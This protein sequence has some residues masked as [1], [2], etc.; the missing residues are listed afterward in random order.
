MG[1]QNQNAMPNSALVYGFIVGIAFLPFFYLFKDLCIPIM[2]MLTIPAVLNLRGSFDKLV[3]MAIPLFLSLIMGVGAIVQLAVAILTPSMILGRLSLIQNQDG[4]YYPIDRLVAVFGFYTLGIGVLALLFWN[5][6]NG[7]DLIMTLFKE[8]LKTIPLENQAQSTAIQGA[9]GKIWP[10]IPGVYTLT[11]T[12]LYS[13][14]VALAQQGTLQI[15]QPTLWGLPRPR[16]L[17]SDLYVPWVFWKCFAA[18]GVAAG[19]TY[20]MSW[21]P[22]FLIFC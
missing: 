21:Q 10:Y 17:L 12:I 16:L 7:S 5:G 8:Q 20:L 3:F 19:V 9:L 22:V 2:V 18:L 14:G 11:F 15:W 13:I 4:D 6:L 1:K